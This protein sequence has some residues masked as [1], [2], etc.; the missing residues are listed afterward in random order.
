MS[1]AELADFIQFARQKLDSNQQPESLEELLCQ[2]RDQCT[3]VA[4]VE[5]IRQGLD[6]YAAGRGESVENAFRDLRHQ[7]GLRD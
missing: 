1:K 5:D 3:L 7:L 2:W 4:T 6:D